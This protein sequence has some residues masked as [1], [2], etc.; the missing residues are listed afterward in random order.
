M[1]VLRAIIVLPG[2][3][4]IVIPGAI[5]WISST[6]SG[7]LEPAT[8]AQPA[9]WIGVLLAVPGLVLASWTISLFFVSGRGTLA[10]WDPPT[11]LVV[12]GP[13]RHVRNPIVTGV[14]LM[15]AAESLIFRSWPLAAWLTTFFIG[16]TANLVK[17]EEPDLERRFGDDDVR[18]KANVPRWIPRWR[19]QG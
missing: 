1:R 14:L 3:V 4:L 11:M 8:P 5:L 9:F 10:P 16:F 7:S 12:L 2:T 18:Y 17:V 15:L 6:V 19:P 13:Y